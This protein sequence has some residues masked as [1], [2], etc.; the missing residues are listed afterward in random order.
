LA[1]YINAKNLG[2]TAS[3]IND[4]A[5]PRLSLLSN[6]AG[7]QGTLSITNNTIAGLNFNLTAGSNASLTVDGVPVSSPSNTVTGAIPGVTL[8]LVSAAPSTP[9]T[10]TVGSDPGQITDAV[11]NFVSAYNAVIQSVNT[12]FT[13]D[14]NTNTE[15]PLGSDS[16]I[17][18]LQSSLLSDVSHA[19]SGNGGLINLASLGIDLNNDGTLSVNQTATDL[20]PSFANVLA[21]NPG[22]V[23]SF[24][25]NSSGTGFADNFST[26]L[27]NLIDST[28][29][30]VTSD[31]AENNAKKL[32][33]TN[34][35]NNFQG[36]L[37]AEQR[38]LTTVF[39]QVNATLQAYPLLL[40]QV[41]Q[42]L[43]ALPSTGS[44][45]DTGGTHPVLTSG[46]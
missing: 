46:L 35:I 12:Q 20:K 38:Q 6:T 24:F 40:Q 27:N 8:N 31:I 45:G 16:S 39:A 41:T 18:S 5:G 13:V 22:A 15:G 11:N 42:T 29:G 23:Q 32:D 33:L 2:V 4:A 21:A 37:A 43:A 17:R 9:V 25:Q 26:D 7:Q 44:S 19:I 34:S 36:Q 10:L 14:P 28:S 1:S 3:V 30:V